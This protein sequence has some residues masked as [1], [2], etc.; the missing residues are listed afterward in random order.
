M[1]AARGVR[2]ESAADGVG[3]ESAADGVRVESGTGPTRQVP[4]VHLT[5]RLTTG[6]QGWFYFAEM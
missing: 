3:I 4:V 5:V 1:L 2:I 6:I